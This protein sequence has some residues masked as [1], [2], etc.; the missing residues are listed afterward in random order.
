MCV[1]NPFELVVHNIVQLIL[2]DVEFHHR[3]RAENRWTE[4]KAGI[5]STSVF[6]P[7]FLSNDFGA[8]ALASQ[9]GKRLIALSFVFVTVD[10]SRRG[11]ARRRC[12][13][14]IRFEFSFESALSQFPIQVQV[15]SRLASSRSVPLGWLVYTQ[16]FISVTARRT[17]PSSIAMLG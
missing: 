8:D 10:V 11:G 13:V 17:C 9:F 12:W 1:T 5:I 6:A 15:V 4:G 16:R 14:I 2:D 7:V 3:I